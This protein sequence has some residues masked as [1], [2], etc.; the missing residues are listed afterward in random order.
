MQRVDPRVVILGQGKS[1][2]AGDPT[3]DFAFRG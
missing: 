2:D 3:I 1:K